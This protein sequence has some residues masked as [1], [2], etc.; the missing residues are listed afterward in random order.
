MEK[1]WSLEGRVALVTGGTSGIGLAVAGQLLER[2]AEVCVVA[3]TAA[4]VEA[5]VEE[6]RREGLPAHGVTADVAEED[7]RRAVLDFARGTWGRLDALVNNVGTNVRKRAV[8]YTDDEYARLMAT[9]LT[10][11]F[12]L[13]RGAH[14]LLKAA[15]AASVVNVVSVAGLTHVGTGAPYAMSKAALVQLTRNLAVE[16]AQDGVRVNAVAPWYI[17][18]PLAE[19]VLRDPEYLAKVVERTPMRRVGTPDE[20]AAAVTFLCMPAAGYVTGQCLAVDGGFTVF[21]FQP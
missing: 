12:A 11:A 10:S 15:G 13:T 17:A 20:A 18:T 16:W 2:G 4:R 5:W 14:P 1:L 19:Q 6:R 9:N 7:G 8:E 3:R 21:G